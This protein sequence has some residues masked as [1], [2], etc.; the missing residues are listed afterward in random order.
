MGRTAEAS[1]QKDF[2]F[3][4]CAIVWFVVF[5]LFSFVVLVLSCVIMFMFLVVCLY[6]CA[7][8]H[9]YYM[10]KT[11]MC[12]CLAVLALLVVIILTLISI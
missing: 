2:A 5:A 11:N 6:C 4:L 10:C 7:V 1:L 8:Y 9:C 3:P 12:S